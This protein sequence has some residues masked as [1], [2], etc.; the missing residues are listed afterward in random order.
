MTQVPTNREQPIDPRTGKFSVAW[1]QFFRKLAELATTTAEAQASD[2]GGDD[3]PQGWGLRA[4]NRFGQVI[5]TLT[6]SSLNITDGGGVDANPAIDLL[7]LAD[8]TIGDALV[9]ITRDEYGRVEGTEPA[10]A[11]DLPYDDELTFGV[12]NAQA[13]LTKAL[14]AHW[15]FSDTAPDPDEHPNWANTDTGTLFVWY[16]DGTSASW[17]E[18]GTGGGSSDGAV[19]YAIAAGETFT[20][21]TNKQA[22]FTLPIDVE[23]TLVVDGY[24]VEV[25]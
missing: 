7:S 20:V 22:L 10:L 9:K 24:L 19:P 5:R 16:D 14:G 25:S 2:T 17:V 13:A 3:A 4:Q 12:A 21:A 18:F 8:T 6:S 1:D 15:Y 23:G 11:V